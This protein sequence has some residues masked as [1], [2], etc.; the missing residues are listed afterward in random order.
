MD[1][2]TKKDTL[3]VCKGLLDDINKNEPKV[4]MI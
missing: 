4:D 1:K 3:D 2:E